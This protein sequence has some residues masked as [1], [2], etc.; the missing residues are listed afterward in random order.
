MVIQPLTDSRSQ[1][2]YILATDVPV[3]ERTLLLKQGE[4][5]G[6]FNEFGDIDA[7]AR[8]EEGLYN[9]GTRYLSGLS[10]SLASHRPLLLSSTVRRDNLLMVVD[11]T[12]PDLYVA[13]QLVLPRG[14]LHINRTKVLWLDVCYEQIRIRNFSLAELEIDLA[15]SCSGRLR[16]HLR[17]AWPG[18]VR[19][20]AGSIRP[21]LLIPPSC[22]ATTGWTG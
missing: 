17:S 8:R 19:D 7:A 14:T 15:L 11:L 6:V 16:R 10:L 22:C 18:R 13:G 4:T 12:N 21:R 1:R 2:Y 20:A 9:A 3:A 5:F